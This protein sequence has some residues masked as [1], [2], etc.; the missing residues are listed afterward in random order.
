M[1]SLGGYRLCSYVCLV[2]QDLLCS[3]SPRPASRRSPTRSPTERPPFAGALFG[4]QRTP[5][6][7]SGSPPPLGESP[8]HGVLQASTL[9]EELRQ[10][11]ARAGAAAEPEPHA[12]EAVQRTATR[13]PS[14][15][16]QSKS[17]RCYRGDVR[18]GKHYLWK[19]RILMHGK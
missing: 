14:A 16:T 7:A 8:L 6:Q 9:T 5:A 15:G 19:K 18:A 4:A 2:P 12:D 11:D 1:K 10:R 3:L 13:Q 17:T